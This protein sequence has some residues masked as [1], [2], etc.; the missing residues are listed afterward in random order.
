VDSIRFHANVA[1]E[2]KIASEFRFSTSSPT[3]IPCTVGLYAE[4]LSRENVDHVLL[5]CDTPAAAS[6]EEINHFVRHIEDIAK[7]IA[8]IAPL[9][10]QAGKTVSIIILTA[11]SPN[12]TTLVDALQ[13]FRD[14]PVSIILR[15]CNNDSRVFTFWKSQDCKLKMNI[16]VLDDMK[17]EAEEV[18]VVNPWITYA[19]PLHRMREFGVNMKELD[20]LDEQLI[21]MEGFQR[22][23]RIL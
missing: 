16:D 8:S 12:D 4:E 14:L 10:R 23:C 2:G 7:D 6:T 5:Q 20:L 21:P 17:G 3:M 15:L 1:F 11:S 13:P 9:L 18:H 22:V 19:D